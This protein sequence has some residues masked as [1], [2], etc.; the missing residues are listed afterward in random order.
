MS[1]IVFENGRFGRKT[2]I[3]KSAEEA[4]VL[5]LLRSFLDSNEPGLVRL[6]VNTWNAQGKAITYKTLREA[7]LSGE[8]DPELL[9]EWQ[10]DYSRFV[11][12][13]LSSAWERAIKQSVK[14]LELRYATWV[15]DPYAD[16]I[17]Q[18]VSTRSASFVTNCTETQIEGLRAVIQR[19]A[20]MEVRNVD[21]LARVI[22]PMVGLT[23]QQAN[24][25]LN[26]YQTLLDSGI[27]PEK[28]KDLTIRYSA[29]QHR[30]RAYTIAR[31]E[32]STAYNE[33]A[34][35]GTR[36][37][38]AAG[39]MG[40]CVKVWSTADDERTCPACDFL[41]S[42]RVG[43]DDDFFFETKDRYGNV[44]ARRI[45]ASLSE[46]GAGQ[47]PPAHPGCRC[48]VVYKEVSKPKKEVRT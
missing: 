37:A 45:N 8:L 34:L 20:L 11:K 26:Y 32:L 42:K 13:H 40:E 22:R 5:R 28:A 35:Q 25:S 15:F 33:G 4:A 2:T 9:D 31:T 43:M 41:E 17:R 29:Q 30:S 16:G 12:N 24:A 3:T 23:R 36:Q 7:I 48:A 19:A 47:R 6:L 44:I 10:Q 46:P 39:Y 38:Q 14:P 1:G 18:W 27:K 21:D